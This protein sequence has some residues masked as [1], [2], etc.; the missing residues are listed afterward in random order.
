MLDDLE[1]ALKYLEMAWECLSQYIKKQSINDIPRS[2]RVGW[3]M[4]AIT[5]SIKYVER[6]IREARK[7][8][9]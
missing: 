6:E 4:T 2:G 3:A 9:A 7:E 1:R 5:H 8:K